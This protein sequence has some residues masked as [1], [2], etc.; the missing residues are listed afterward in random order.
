[1]QRWR[2]IDLA[3]HMFLHRWWLQKL[4]IKFQVLNGNLVAMLIPCSDTYHTRPATRNAGA[5]VLRA[6]REAAHG[7]WFGARR[8]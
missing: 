4:S 2:V 6:R 8:R 5:S 7:H 1:M 3:D